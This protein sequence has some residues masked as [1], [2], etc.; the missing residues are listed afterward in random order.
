MAKLDELFTP[1]AEAR[2]REA[3]DEAE[4]RT[5]G[6]IVPYVVAA[7]DTYASTYYQAGLFGALFGSLVA[8]GIH[9][10]SEFWDILTIPWIAGP[11]F[12]GAALG[13]LAVALVPA[14]RRLLIGSATVDRRTE[15][16]AAVAFLEEEVFKT[17]DRTGIL[18]FLSL[19]EHRVVVMG[20]EGI[21]RAVDAG[22]W[23]AIVAHLVAG[24][25]VGDPA[26]AM[27]NAIQECGKLLDRH[28]VD[29]R[30]DDVDELSDDL[31]L[32]DD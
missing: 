25:R 11:V 26:G 3:V 14:L 27:V 30:P 6:E 18:I 32:R 7:S 29:I 16:R 21:N 1:T 2:I 15:R 9:L 23:D 8:V 12:A 20:D 28:G 13:W 5:S 22:E 17:R 24:I 4:K 10:F 19:F 31:R